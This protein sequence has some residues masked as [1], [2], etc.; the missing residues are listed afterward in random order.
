[1]GGL[2]MNL[3]GVEFRYPYYSQGASF[4]YARAKQYLRY[5]YGWRLCVY[6]C[7]RGKGIAPLIIKPEHYITKYF[8]P[9]IRQE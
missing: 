1:M 6:V 8:V 3:G 7:V 9:D 4:T 5:N 2:D